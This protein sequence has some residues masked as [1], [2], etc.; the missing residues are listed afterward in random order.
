MISALGTS[1]NITDGVTGEFSIV[2]GVDGDSWRKVADLP[3]AR[4]CLASASVDGKIYAI[5]GRTGLLSIPS[6][7]VNVVDE[8]NPITDTWRSRA[9][10][11]TPRTELA[12]AAAVVNGRIYV[13]GGYDGNDTTSVVEEYDPITDTWRSRAP[14]PTARERL[15]TAVVNGRIYTIGG[16]PSGWPNTLSTVEEYDPATDTWRSRAAMPTARYDLSAAVVDGRIYT[17]GGWN[18]EYL[19]VVEEYNPVTNQ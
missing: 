18:S 4:C 16:S 14:M 1:S 5:G 12:D 10:M 2:T 13:F 7:T 15:A 3:T 19:A 9:P 17:I 8:Y 11:P 6:S